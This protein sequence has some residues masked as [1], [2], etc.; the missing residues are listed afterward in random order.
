MTPRAELRK[1]IEVVVTM[2]LDEARTYRD[3][4]MDLDIG[5]PTDALFDVLD[6]AVNEAYKM[7]AE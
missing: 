1:H 6:D 2:S 4:L 3:R 7:L 5:D